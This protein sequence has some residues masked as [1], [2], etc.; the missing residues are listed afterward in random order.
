MTWHSTGIACDTKVPTHQW[1]VIRS[2]VEM[3][4][5][6]GLR[7][8]SIEMFH[9]VCRHLSLEDYMALDVVGGVD[10][11]WTPDL[12]RQAALM[13]IGRCVAAS[14]DV[15]TVRRQLAATV[16]P[17]F[18]PKTTH[19]FRRADNTLERIDVLAKRTIKGL[20]YSVVTTLW[21]K[22]HTVEVKHYRFPSAHYKYTTTIHAHVCDTYVVFNIPPTG[23]ITI[24]CNSKLF[25]SDAVVR[26]VLL[27]I[28]EFAKAFNLSFQR[29]MVCIQ[30]SQDIWNQILW[31]SSC[32]E[33]VFHLHNAVGN[34]F[35]FARA[36]FD[37]AQGDSLP[38]CR[39]LAHM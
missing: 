36:Y 26:E 12:R 23:D 17:V 4:S 34:M 3:R 22:G 9:L 33:G 7:D 32:I 16:Y 8:L 10:V 6:L 27:L 20:L 37:T 18:G 21:W 15:P 31:L 2:F 39:A 28:E 29:R 11:P 13:T 38:A 24:K 35:V 30:F 25:Y 19:Q 1:Q 14:D 5:S